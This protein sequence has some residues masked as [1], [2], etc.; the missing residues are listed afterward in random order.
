LSWVEIGAKSRNLGSW[1]WVV[2]FAGLKMWGKCV[3]LEVRS[4]THLKS[5]NDVKQPHGKYNGSIT[6]NS[7]GKAGEGRIRFPKTCKKGFY[8]G[9]NAKRLVA[10]N[11]GYRCTSFKHRVLYQLRQN[12]IMLMD[13]R[14]EGIEFE[15]MLLYNMESNSE[16]FGTA[17]MRYKES[18]I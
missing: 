9:V 1:K 7:W 8:K 17:M 18:I 11:F 10:D 13:Y 15:E 12:L 2:S 16:L 5:G 4:S 14:F 3:G 6:T